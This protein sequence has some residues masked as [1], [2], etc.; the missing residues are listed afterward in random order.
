MNEY[1]LPYITHTPY[2]HHTIHTIPI[3]FEFVFFS[4]YFSYV[5]KERKLLFLTDAVGF[6][7]FLT[8]YRKLKDPVLNPGTVKSVFFPQKYFEFLNNYFFFVEN[9]WRITEKNC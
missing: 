3:T 2:T 7:I 4:K 9:Y 5:I 8:V 1:V 6:E